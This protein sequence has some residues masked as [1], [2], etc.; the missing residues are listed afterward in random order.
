M[1]YCN[2]IKTFNTIQKQR[3]TITF[4][5][6]MS[7]TKSLYKIK[8]HFSHSSFQPLEFSQIKRNLHHF[9]ILQLFSSLPY[10]FLISNIL[11]V[12]PWYSILPPF[13]YLAHW[14]SFAIFDWYIT[15]HWSKWMC[16][17]P[18]KHMDAFKLKRNFYYKNI[19]N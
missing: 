13:Y 19:N 9:F 5:Y 17:N 6:L 18:C 3:E 1:H 14:C 8:F 11:S 15:F 4:S 7:M 2:K 10:Q 12:V 16:S